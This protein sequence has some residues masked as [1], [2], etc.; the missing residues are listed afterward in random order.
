MLPKRPVYEDK[1]PTIYRSEEIEKLLSDR[2]PYRHLVMLLALKTGLR[3]K[4]LR[5]LEFSDFD[6]SERTLRVRGKQKW[7][8][9]VKAVKTT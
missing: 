7:N 8:F 3:D 2:D 5:H 6:F 1:L 9:K 4:E